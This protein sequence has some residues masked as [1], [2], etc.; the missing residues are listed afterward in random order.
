MH[1]FLESAPFRRRDPAV[2]DKASAIAAQGARPPP[3]QTLHLCR[4]AQ[5][6]LNLF[7]MFKGVFSAKFVHLKDALGVAFEALNVD[8]AAWA[9]HI[10]LPG[11]FEFGDVIEGGIVAVVALRD[12]F[13]EGGIA[14]IEQ[15]RKWRAAGFL[16]IAIDLGQDNEAFWKAHLTQGFDWNAVG[17]TAIEEL[18]AVDFDDL[19]HNRQGGTGTQDIHAIAPHALG[20]PVVR[21]ACLDIA[22]RDKELACRGFEGVVIEWHQALGEIFVAKGAANK[23]AGQKQTFETK[24][25][26]IAAEGKVVSNAAPKLI[27]QKR[28]AMN[29]TRRHADDPIEGNLALAQ[30]V[31]HAGRINT[32]GGAAFQYKSSL[33]SFRC[34]HDASFFFFTRGSQRPR[35]PCRADIICPYDALPVGKGRSTSFFAKIV[36][37]CDGFPAAKSG[38]P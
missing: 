14:T 9:Q 10:D 8:L 37:F 7:K 19:R 23:V 35:T 25:A 6:C 13:D 38:K 20:A 34:A 5:E 33:F 1:C 36:V 29:G 21:F 31:K 22:A 27:R 26:R 3:H 11:G 30:Y 2:S 28:Y 16:A 32:A 24:K 17:H 4:I 15:A 12:G 18:S